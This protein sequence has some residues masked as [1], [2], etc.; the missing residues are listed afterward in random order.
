MRPW[1]VCIIRMNKGSHHITIFYKPAL[2]PLKNLNSPGC[3]AIFH[4]QNQHV[5]PSLT[6]SRTAKY[7][8]IFKLQLPPSPSSVRLLIELPAPTRAT[9]RPKAVLW[10]YSQS[11]WKSN[12]YL[13]IPIISVHN[14]KFYFTTLALKTGNSW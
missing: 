6:S 9:W 5:A 2:V 1:L 3:I 14:L 8:S 11:L 12:S 13:F 4:P 10:N 7:K